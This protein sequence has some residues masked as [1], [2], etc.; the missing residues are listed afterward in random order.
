MEIVDRIINIS[1][2][3]KNFAFLLDKKHEKCLDFQSSVIT[4]LS[5]LAW[6]LKLV[7]WEYLFRITYSQLIWTYFIL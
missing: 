3:R 5:L 1:K 2:L 7:K 4:F 6:R